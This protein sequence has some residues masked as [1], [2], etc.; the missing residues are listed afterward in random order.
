MYISTSI[1]KHFFRTGGG[2]IVNRSLVRSVGL[3]MAVFLSDLADR[4]HF[5][6]KK[7]PT[8]EG[9]FF[10]TKETRRKELGLSDSVMERLMKDAVASGFIVTKMA[11]M[12]AKQQ[13]RVIYEKIGRAMEEAV[14]E[15]STEE[16]NENS[17]ASLPETA[18]AS[19]PE[20]RGAS[21]LHK[22]TKPEVL[23]PIMREAADSVSKMERTIRPKE[24]PRPTSSEERTKKYLPIARQLSDI[25]QR[26]K[27]IKVTHAWV[28]NWAYHIRLLHEIDRINP[29]RIQ[30]VLLDYDVLMDTDPFMPVIESG[31]SLRR[32]FIRL[33]AAIDRNKF[34]RDVK[35]NDNRPSQSQH[36]ELTTERREAYVRRTTVMRTD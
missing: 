29:Q 17:G 15:E 11:G 27:K 19:L 5:V 32:K 34:K 8:G 1:F 6:N 21:L 7:S 2:F 18:S 25:I 31:E 22:E 20:D 23:K 28:A 12:P 26:H 24:L 4:D 16:M 36:E 3:E 35:V 33:V 13:I 9:W 10:A 14:V 30:K